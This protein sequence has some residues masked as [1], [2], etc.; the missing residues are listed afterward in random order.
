MPEG[1][2]DMELKNH[3]VP[4]KV[5][6]VLVDFLMVAKL[7]YLNFSLRGEYSG[8]LLTAAPLSSPYEYRHFKGEV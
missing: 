8:E 3:N 5:H 7:D 4:T 6:A 1:L 2:K